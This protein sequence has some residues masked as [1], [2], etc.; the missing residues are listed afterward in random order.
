MKKAMD[1]QHPG[2]GA[3]AERA[4]GRYLTARG[5]KIIDRN[6]HCRGGE[7]DIIGWDGDVLAFVEV[8]YRGNSSLESPLESVTAKK[9]RRIILAAS[10]YLQRNQGWQA[11]C[12]FDVL[13]MT[14]GRIRR[15]RAQWIKNAF[16]T[17]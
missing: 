16:D 15:Y 12:R 5:L 6:V 8:R 14:P 9:Q 13:A 11:Q 17:S 4:A 3:D 10:V 1:G 2:K 7:I